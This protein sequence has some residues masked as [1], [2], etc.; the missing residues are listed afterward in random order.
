MHRE[1]SI[2]YVY[3]ISLVELNQAIK[4]WS[5]SVM[6]GFIFILSSTHIGHY[7]LFTKKV[8][9]RKVARDVQLEMGRLAK[10][11]QAN[12]VIIVPWLV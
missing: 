11:P 4:G 1:S 10:A 9:K 2:F 7:C 8:V 3:L 12:E 6:L 5:F